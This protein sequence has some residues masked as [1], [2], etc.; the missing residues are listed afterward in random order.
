[1]GK[2]IVILI[3]HRSRDSGKKE[4]LGSLLTLICPHSKSILLT[5]PTLMAN[6]P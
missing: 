6:D 2:V 5:S 4:S 1:M 3:G